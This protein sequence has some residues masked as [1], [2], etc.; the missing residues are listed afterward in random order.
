MRYVVG[1][2]GA[3]GSALARAAVERLD[4]LGHEVVVVATQP[5]RE[6]WRQEIGG[7]FAEWQGRLGRR[8]VRFFDASDFA[9]PIASGSYPVDGMIVIPCSVGTV[10]AIAQGNAAN[11][12]QRAADCAI[13]EGRRLVLVPREA[14]L[15]PIHLQNLLRLARLGVRIVPPVPAFYTRPR[16]LDDVVDQIAGR[17]LASL[18]VPNALDARFIYEGVSN[19]D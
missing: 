5:A 3:S 19:D 4:A 15:S 11:L 1:I 9:A 13:K 18:G 10:A 7:P 16:T 12:L 6:V 2:S 14:P 17:A 8:G